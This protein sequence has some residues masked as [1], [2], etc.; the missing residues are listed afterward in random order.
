[1]KDDRRRGVSNASVKRQG[2]GWFLTGTI[3]RVTGDVTVLQTKLIEGVPQRSID[4][5]APEIVGKRQSFG[6]LQ[7]CGSFTVP[8]KL[9]PA[10]VHSSNPR[11]SVIGQMAS[12]KRGCVPKHLLKV[13]SIRHEA[14]PAV[15]YNVVPELVHGRK[16]LGS[17]CR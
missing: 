3:D 9:Q 16:I 17:R 1:M 10:R 4:D 13:R 12:Y 8:H 2:V 15:S 5:H 7:V 11:K 6:G 14:V